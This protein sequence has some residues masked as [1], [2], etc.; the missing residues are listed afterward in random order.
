MVC[1]CESN[2]CSFIRNNSTIASFALSSASSF[3]LVLSFKCNYKLP[4]SAAS[5]LGIATHR[6]D[7]TDR[8]RLG[9]AYESNLQ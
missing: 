2:C 6:S 1:I 5:L 9:L 4:L 8:I 3:Y 7:K